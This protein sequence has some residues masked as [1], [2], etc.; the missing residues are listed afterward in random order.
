[1]PVS[2][3]RLYT[4]KEINSKQW[5]SFVER[6]WNG[7][8]YAYSWY[9]DI[10]TKGRWKAL[11]NADNSAV[12]PLPL[13]PLRFGFRQMLK[14]RTGW[15]TWV[16]QPLFC[17]Q[18]GLFAERPLQKD[19][20]TVFLKELFR[21]FPKIAVYCLNENMSLPKKILAGAYKMRTNYLLDLNRA[22]KE[23]RRGY[24]ASHRRALKKSK[25]A[26]QYKESCAFSET[27]FQNHARYLGKKTGLN[28]RAYRRWATL[29]QTVMHKK[30][31]FFARVKNHQKTVC[32]EAFILQSHN[33][34]IYQ[35]GYVL[36]EA[37]ARMPM[38]ALFDGLIQR[39][40]GQ[41]LLLDFEGSDLPG[42]AE[43]FRRF[44]AQKRSYGCVWRG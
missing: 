32:A 21:N 10:V 27:F 14:R 39:H 25:E 42:V 19:E 30:Q 24:S 44:G 16:L 12:M 4:R 5:D 43:F 8:P 34:L 38:H 29:A 26:W 18:L 9:L 22:Y 31:G 7:L 17:Q 33:R 3:L 15:H 41:K 2:N 23:I 35:G 6:S 37:Q 40:A 28:Q 36:P 20:T 11:I 1:M 13:A